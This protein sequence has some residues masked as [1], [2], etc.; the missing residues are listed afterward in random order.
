MGK[1]AQTVE[2]C[3]RR[4]TAEVQRLIDKAFA[5]MGGAPEPGS[6]WDQ[7]GLRDGSEIIGEYL[8]YGEPGVALEHLLYMITE[9]DLSL[10]V[11]TVTLVQEA[12]RR[13][14]FPE[15][16]CGGIHAADSSTKPE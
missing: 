9:T 8:R 3:I 11:E 15:E 7:L 10:S 5:E 16:K 6:C 1:H 13:M 4:A 14:N 12:C 2:E